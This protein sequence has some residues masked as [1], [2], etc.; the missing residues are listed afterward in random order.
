MIPYYL[1]RLTAPMLDPYHTYYTLSLMSIHRIPKGNI[2]AIMNIFILKTFGIG[3]S[4]I[5]FTVSMID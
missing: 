4:H 5:V 1:S 3:I 2:G